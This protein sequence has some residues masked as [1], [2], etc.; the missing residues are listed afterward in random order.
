[1]RPT[2]RY[3]SGTD[4]ATGGRRGGYGTGGHRMRPRSHHCRG[5]TDADAL[6][7]AVVVDDRTG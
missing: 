1:M 7:L 6:S 5:G 4:V 3:M 2:L